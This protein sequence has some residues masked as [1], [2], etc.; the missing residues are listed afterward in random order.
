MVITSCKAEIFL[1]LLDLKSI[2]SFLLEKQISSLINLT[3]RPFPLQVPLPC[4]SF[5]I[6]PLRP[7]LDNSS[8][9]CKA[10]NICWWHII[11]NMLFLSLS[12]YFPVSKLYPFQRQESITLCT[13]QLTV[14]LTRECTSVL[15]TEKWLSS[16]NTWWILVEE[17]C[18][19]FFSY[20]YYVV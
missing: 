1:F 3:L 5:F 13:V 8:Y 20:F 14:Y 16:S 15:R 18:L 19:I 2:L 4:F 11:S 17:A 9:S 12:I 7:I 6:H 10:F